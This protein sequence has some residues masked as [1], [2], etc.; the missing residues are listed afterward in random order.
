[1]TPS[2]DMHGCRIGAVP[3]LADP[4]PGSAI[5]MSI[6]SLHEMTVVMVLHVSGSDKGSTDQSYVC[7]LFSV[8][9]T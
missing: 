9:F 5:P 8:V 3:F 6:H 7:V 4:F 2:V 1:M